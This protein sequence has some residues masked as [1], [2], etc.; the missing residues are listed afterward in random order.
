MKETRDIMGMPIT[1]D[2]VDDCDQSDIQEV[3][4]YFT[5]VDEKFSTYKETSEITEINR[6]KIQPENYSPEM[7]EVFKLSEET[8]NISKGYFDIHRPD[9]K[10][11]PSG[12]V[13]GWAIK[14]AADI[15]TKKAFRNFYVEAGGDI[16]ARGYNQQS[17]KWNVGIRNPFNKSEIVKVVHISNQGMATSGN[18]E[19]GN[20]IYNPLDVN[21]EL[22]EIVS[23]TVIGPNI[24]EADRFATAGFAMGREGINFIESIEGLEGYMI[25]K[26]GMATMTSGFERYTQAASF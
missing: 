4:N 7:K 25:D 21:R 3:F 22:D 18:Y 14:N 17:Q 12:L 11:D 9:G 16:E 2:V 24:Y 20:H 10:I 26:E 6:N 19:R 15:L 5:K 13:K 23:L 1:V 8:K